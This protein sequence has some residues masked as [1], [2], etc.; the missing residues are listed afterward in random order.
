MPE[1]TES[2]TEEMISAYLDGE[3][4]IEQR[5]TVEQSMAR[6]PRYG[7]LLQQ[8]QSLRD[9]LNELPRH[10][11]DENFAQR[12]LQRIES[13]PS[14]DAIH[15]VDGPS[16]HAS[17]RSADGPPD[18][19]PQLIT[20]SRSRG[21]R[22]GLM[23]SALAAV[24][25]AVVML[26]AP[27]TARVGNQVASVRERQED[28]APSDR[29]TPDQINRLG[30]PEFV[31]PQAPTVE[32]D[33]DDS[34]D[35]IRLQLAPPAAGDDKTVSEQLSDA[36]GSPA[37]SFREPSVPRQAADLSERDG[38]LRRARPESL[39]SR[40]PS[41]PIVPNGIE[42]NDRGV[43]RAEVIDG[44]FAGR[45][46]T[47]L[48][49]DVTT[50]QLADLLAQLRDDQISIVADTTRKSSAPP[51]VARGTNGNRAT[52]A[53]D[54]LTLAFTGAPAQRAIVVQAPL[55]DVHE[56]LARANVR[57]RMLDASGVED[58]NIYFGRSNAVQAARTFR[59]TLEGT[60]DAEAPL[61]PTPPPGRGQATGPQ[62][63]AAQPRTETL[64]D[65][66]AT[67]NA[68]PGEPAAMRDQV[69]LLLRIIDPSSPPPATP[70]ANGAP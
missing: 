55:S 2:I 41:P 31:A 54:D 13:I 40:T 49:A 64:A 23:W 36:P 38:S 58:L 27:E 57:G 67:T 30:E 61:S 46:P 28:A 20:V 19:S 34:A 8:L 50:E 44:D 42:L 37:T 26:F 12:V 17:A 6:D 66:P 14:E 15:S 25:A 11:L 9:G 4:T 69:L 24:A 60:P 7:Q 51:A 47:V 3:L 65:E 21:W 16:D 43:T 68:A 45:A 22:R 29:L 52:T 5:R 62:P 32:S 39:E 56:S 53:D 18:G 10:H 33:G 1:R 35:D 48:Q 63:D 70:P 59:R